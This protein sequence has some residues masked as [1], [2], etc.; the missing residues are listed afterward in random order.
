MRRTVP[1][2]MPGG[3]KIPSYADENGDS[4][5]LWIALGLSPASP[6]NIDTDLECGG[7]TEYQVSSYKS[8]Q[9][10][11]L[12]EE[13]LLRKKIES[14]EKEEF[15]EFEACNPESSKVIGPDRDVES[16]HDYILAI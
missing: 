6:K 13:N 16:C 3:I 10:E 15:S 12:I 7:E 9:L 14:A 4:S 8:V 2:I 5:S 11:E 1:S